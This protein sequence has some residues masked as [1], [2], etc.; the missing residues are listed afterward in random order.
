M[1]AMRLTLVSMSPF[2]KVQWTTKQEQSDHR[3]TQRII[4]MPPQLLS[5][6]SLTPR[7]REPY[8]FTMQ[9]NIR[10]FIY[11]VNLSRRKPDDWEEQG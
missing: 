11:I 1:L 5:L 8:T 3:S 10:T 9:R 2:E 4:S 6:V 7:L